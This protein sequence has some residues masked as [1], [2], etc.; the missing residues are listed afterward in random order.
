M[1]NP[2][3]LKTYCTLAELKHFTH[4]ANALYMTQSGVSQHIQKLEQQLDIQLLLRE[5]KSFTLTDAGLRLYQNGKQLLQASDDLVTSI[6]QDDAYVGNIRVA[7]PGSIGLKLYPQLLDIQQKHPKLSLDYTFAPNSSIETAL[8]DRN[9][10]IGLMTE[11]PKTSKLNSQKIALEPLVLVT[12]NKVTKINWQIL[13]ELGFILHPDVKHHA[14]LLLSENF[15][16][17]EQI[18][19]F[20]HKG[21]SNQISL[22]LEPVSRNIGFTILPLHAVNAFHQQQKI[23]IQPLAKPVSENL[24]LCQN[25]NAFESARNKQLKAIIIDF[26]ST[27]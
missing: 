5:G 24:Y 3:W 7:S 8:I 10:D 21:F 14:N 18:D 22:I 17:F 11:M 16:E 6:K 25:K 15:K 1:V 23:R 13:T 19:Q 12:S 2:L 20:E 27:S 4:T 26:L 9:I